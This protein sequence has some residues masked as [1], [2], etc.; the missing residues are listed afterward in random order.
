MRKPLPRSSSARPAMHVWCLSS[1]LFLK[2]CKTDLCSAF[3]F[4]KRSPS[5]CRRFQR[6]M[7]YL[8]IF[9]V[10]FTVA[11]SRLR[12]SRVRGDWESA[13]TF[14]ANVIFTLIN[15]QSRKWAGK[16]KL[17]TI[18]M[19]ENWGKS[20]DFRIFIINSTNDKLS[21]NLVTWYKFTFAVYLIKVARYSFSGS[22]PP[23][24]EA[25]K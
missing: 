15:S 23:K 16:K 14:T 9:R 10:T 2:Y 21:E 20:T 17:K 8:G 22:I 1:L 13:A 18:L 3:T 25:V 11:C 6:V 24:F 5:P 4:V 19:D 7:F 12:D